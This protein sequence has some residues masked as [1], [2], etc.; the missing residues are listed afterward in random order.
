MR[1]VVITDENGNSKLGFEYPGRAGDA[2]GGEAA[3]AAPRQEAPRLTAA[4]TAGRFGRR[5][6][7]RRP[8]F[9]AEGAARQGLTIAVNAILAVLAQFGCEPDRK[10]R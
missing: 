6:S 2:A 7:A 9:G 8:R 3:R 10:D 4:E 1:V 5:Q